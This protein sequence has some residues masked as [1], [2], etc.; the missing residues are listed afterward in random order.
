MIL[1]QSSQR[2]F[3]DSLLTNKISSSNVIFY[4]RKYVLKVWFCN[5]THSYLGWHIIKQI[6]KIIEWR[7]WQKWWNFENESWTSGMAWAIIPSFICNTVSDWSLT[8]WPMSDS[9]TRD[10][11]EFHWRG[12]LNIKCCD[13]KGFKMPHLVFKTIQMP[14]TS[15]VC[16]IAV[17]WLYLCRVDA[18][19]KC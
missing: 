16:A 7:I 9:F 17:I 15:C 14:H 12:K 19:S 4:L 6:Y 11:W 13:K 5:L 10:V 8:F 3:F 18:T 2:S 1:S